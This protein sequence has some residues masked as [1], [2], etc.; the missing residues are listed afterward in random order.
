MADYGLCRAPGCDKPAYTKRQQLCGMHAARLKRGGTL[1]KRVEK[2]TLSQILEG[3]QVFGDWMVIG[4]GEPYV[5]P[6]NGARV[7]SALCRCCCGV[8]RSVPIHTLKQGAS[9]HCGCKVSA[10]ITNMKT[11]HGLH[12]SPEYRTYHHMRDRCLNQ[13]SADWPNY[14]GRGIT[15]CDRWLASFEAFYT[16]MGPRP[17]NRSIDRIDNDGNYEPSNCRWATAKE[18]RNNQRRP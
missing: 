10:I 7:R 3:R 4:E 5:R 17:A 1:E 8:K 15:I 11:T 13:N 18:Q 16:D 6:D 12:D 14:G 2:M 9:K